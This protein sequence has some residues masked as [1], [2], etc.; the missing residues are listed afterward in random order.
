[1]LQHSGWLRAAVLG[2][3]EA[4]CQRDCSG[5]RYKKSNIIDWGGGNRCWGALNGG[6]KQVALHCCHPYCESS[7]PFVTK[8]KM[9]IVDIG[10]QRINIILAYFSIWK[11]KQQCA[12]IFVGGTAC[13][14]RR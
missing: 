2:V 1:M 8:F 12:K 7:Q 6:K 11:L 10:L 13:Q 5:E 9:P 3:N 4:C 14:A